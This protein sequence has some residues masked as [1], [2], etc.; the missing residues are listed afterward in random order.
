MSHSFT[1]LWIHAIWAT[2]NRQEL[3]DYFIEEKVFNYI[4]EELI[5]LG[6]P[7]RIINGMPDHVHVLFLQNPQKT[8]SDLMKQV[9]GGSSHAINGENLILE[10]FAWQTGFAA[11]SVSESQLDVVYNYIKN[12]KQHHLNKN[13]QDE[14]DEFVKLHG[15]ASK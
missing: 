9:K 1:K 10:K 4:R 2:K 3:I 11:F 8:I 12:Q 14:F 13:G 7:V 6:C 5:E 15:L